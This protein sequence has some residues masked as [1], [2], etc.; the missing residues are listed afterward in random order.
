[1]KRVRMS[2]VLG[3]VL[4]AVL[5][6]STARPVQA[7][8]VILLENTS[9][10]GFKAAVIGMSLGG[11]GSCCDIRFGDTDPPTPLFMYGGAP[12]SA[13]NPPPPGETA[14]TGPHASFGNGDYVEFIEVQTNAPSSPGFSWDT[15]L[16][17]EIVYPAE[18]VVPFDI[19]HGL[20][21]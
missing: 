6:T 12:I 4:V 8:P 10:V 7:L 11:P 16:S 15:G 13:S 14:F 18:T 19:A 1:M 5:G 9:S 17:V 21:V 20:G 3:W 2:W